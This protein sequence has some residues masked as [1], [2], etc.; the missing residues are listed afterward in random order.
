[1]YHN[2]IVIWNVR[3]LNA[4]ARRSTIRSLILS[5]DTSSTSASMNRAG[6]SEQDRVVATGSV[7]GELTGTLASTASTTALGGASGRNT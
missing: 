6:V 1:M 4:C 5:V 7:H 2:K 3:G